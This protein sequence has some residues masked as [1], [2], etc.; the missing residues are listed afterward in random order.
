MTP[1]RMGLGLGLGFADKEEEEEE[2]A[3]A[4]RRVEDPIIT[5]EAAL[6]LPF[7]RDTTLFNVL[8]VC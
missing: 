1:V 4:P 7:L 5:N 2:D 6:E 8:G 3:K